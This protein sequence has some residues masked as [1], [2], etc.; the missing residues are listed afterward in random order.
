MANE[1]LNG[2][3]ETVEELDNTAEEIDNLIAKSETFVEKHGKQIMIGVAAFVAIVVGI[4]FYIN[5]YRKPLNIEA[6]EQMSKA[7][8]AFQQDSFAVALNGTGTTP[9]FLTIIDEYGSTDAGNAAKM[10]AGLCYKA[11]GQNEEAVKYLKDYSASKGIVKPAIEGAIGDCYWDLGNLDQAINYYK[12]A[13][14]SEDQMVAPTYLMRL[15]EVY[16]EKQDN[17]KAAETFETIKSKYPNS[18]EARDIDKYI[19]TAN[20]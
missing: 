16:M 15:G 6:A 10:Y 3:N 19:E 8:E 14:E 9:G 4:L 13:A 12:K 2:V 5:A 1:K 18:V 7:E 20:K 17:K 11:L